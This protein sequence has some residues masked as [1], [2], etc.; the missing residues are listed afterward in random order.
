MLF[1]CRCQ[2]YED[3]D[4][5]GRIIL[6]W[7]LERERGWGS[8]DWIGLTQGRDQWRTLVNTAMNL[9]VP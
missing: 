7:T 6:R 9:R 2:N 1:S 8:M 5:D 3:L 4:V